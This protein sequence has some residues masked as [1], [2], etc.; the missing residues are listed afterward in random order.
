MKPTGNCWSWS[1]LSWTGT[2]RHFKWWVGADRRPQI[3][4]SQNLN[5][6]AKN[7]LINLGSWNSQPLLVPLSCI[8]PENIMILQWKIIIVY[9]RTWAFMKND[10]FHVHGDWRNF[11]RPRENLLYIYACI[12][13]RNMHMK[14][15]QNR[16]IN[17]D[18]HWNRNDCKITGRRG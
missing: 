7:Q 11:R 14:N 12:S 3:P 4:H 16:T 18:T 6:F 15:Y 17:K 13:T 9:W 1:L 10:F 5:Q 8:F 2:D